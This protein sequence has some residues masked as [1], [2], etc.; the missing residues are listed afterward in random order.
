MRTTIDGQR[1]LTV[2]HDR[3]SSAINRLGCDDSIDIGLV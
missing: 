1:F 2:S 3:I